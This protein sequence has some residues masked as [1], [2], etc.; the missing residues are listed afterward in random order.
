MRGMRKSER[1]GTQA[2]LTA[3]LLFAGMW[4][5]PSLAWA[6][7]TVIVPVIVEGALSASERRDVRDLIADA[8][9]EAG[10]E[11]EWPERVSAAYDHHLLPC[12]D[13]SCARAILTMT[14][15]RLLVEVTLH[16]PGPNAGDVIVRIVDAEGHEREVR[17]D[18]GTRPLGDVVRAAV[19]DCRARPSGENTG[20]VAVR[21]EGTPIGA[22]VSIDGAQSGALPYE[23]R[24]DLGRHELLVS[25]AG[26]APHRDHIAVAEGMAPLH[27][28]LQALASGGIADWAV[29]VGIGAIVAGLVTAV[30]P[31]VASYAMAGCTERDGTGLCQTVN[32]VDDAVWAWP[33][34]GGILVVAGVVLLV[35]GLTSS[36]GAHVE[37]RLGPG[38]LTV[39][40]SF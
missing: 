30:V 14:N 38:S 4:L 15:T 36:N 19:A 20:G 5:V 29:P 17:Q 25:A 26:Y 6:E 32:V 39:E 13:R 21:I 34:I 12:V 37:A 27:I 2:R 16:L 11:V 22:S 1:S 24:L 28:D 23:G 33:V 7:R 31:P 35:V 18:I 8:V 40:G 10:D 3:A 9:R